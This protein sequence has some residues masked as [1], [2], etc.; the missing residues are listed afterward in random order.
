[1][2]QVGLHHLVTDAAILEPGY[3][4]GKQGVM[5]ISHRTQIVIK[6]LALLREGN[7]FGMPTAQDP[8]LH[9]AP[10]GNVG[11]QVNGTNGIFCRK[12]IDD[13]VTMVQ[14]SAGG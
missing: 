11:G 3:L 14:S 13:I 1:M 12:G 7:G 10:P 6:G 2:P 8:Q 4:A 5:Q 9:P